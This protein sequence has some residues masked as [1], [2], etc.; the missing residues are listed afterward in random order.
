[1]RPG[2]SAQAQPAF[3]LE[4]RRAPCVLIGM[5]QDS[6]YAIRTLLKNP[7][8]TLIAVFA[9]ALGI[10]ANTAIFTV[11]DRVLLRPLP[12]KDADRLVN[13]V[14]KFRTFRKLYPGVISPDEQAIIKQKQANLLPV[15]CLLTGEIHLVVKQFIHVLHSR[16]ICGRPVSKSH[17]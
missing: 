10:G 8:F 13:V 9:L 7:A 4:L 17:S 14:R 16:G 12:Y 6:R 1:L 11:V 15:L 5:G 3:F 2:A